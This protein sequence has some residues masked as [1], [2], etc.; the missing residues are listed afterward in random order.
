MQKFSHVVFSFADAI[1]RHSFRKV[2][3]DDAGKW[4]ASFNAYAKAASPTA[5]QT[6]AARNEVFKAAGLA[7]V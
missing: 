3:Y 6:T 7:V 4:R 2:S 5:A 1:I